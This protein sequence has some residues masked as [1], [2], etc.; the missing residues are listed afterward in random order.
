M[1]KTSLACLLFVLALAK[2]FLFALPSGPA[3]SSSLFHHRKH[4]LGRCSPWDDFEN[5]CCCNPVL[6][7]QLVNMHTSQ[8]QYCRGPSSSSQICWKGLRWAHFW[9]TCVL[10]A[11]VPILQEQ[12]FHPGHFIHKGFAQAFFPCSPSCICH[13]QK[14]PCL[15]SY[16]Q[17]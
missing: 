10:G 6:G 16:L 2:I 8:P 14:C 7:R 1:L 15:L 4:F 12:T 5:S 13:L 9:G 3:H 17:A 11:T